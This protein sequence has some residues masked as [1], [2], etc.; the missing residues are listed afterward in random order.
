MDP[1]TWL[2][3]S[4][5][6]LATQY[7]LAK[8]LERKPQPKPYAAAPEEIQPEQPHPIEEPE[9]IPIE[10]PKPEE[11]RRIEAK[12]EKPKPTQGKPEEA[13]KPKPRKQ[14]TPT[15]ENLEELS[16]KIGQ[17]KDL[18]KLSQDLKKEVEKLAKT[19]TTPK[20]PGKS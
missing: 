19:L 5:T 13:E 7:T 16:E 10:T 17:L 9:P 2:L 3:I 18:L 15:P 6:I 12:P 8:I 1:A 20:T 14:E 11:E 4:I